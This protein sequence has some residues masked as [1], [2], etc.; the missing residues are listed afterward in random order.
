MKTL[1]VIFF[2]M[3]LAMVLGACSEKKEP[4]TIID[5]ND[6]SDCSRFKDGCK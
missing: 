6:N 3:A 5:Q 4:A 1:K 2:A